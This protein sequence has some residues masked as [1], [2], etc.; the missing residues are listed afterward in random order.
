MCVI[1]GASVADNE[2]VVSSPTT[3]SETYTSEPPDTEFA[4]N[5]HG[6]ARVDMLGANLNGYDRRNESV[7]SAFDENRTAI[8]YSLLSIICLGFA[9]G[10]LHC[11]KR[12]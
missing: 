5:T 8:M 11:L 4:V 1:V 7:F 6:T 10:V 2:A 12:Y 3:Y 9:S